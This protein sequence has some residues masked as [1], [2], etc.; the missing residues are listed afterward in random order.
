MT[1]QER[2]M[3]ALDQVRP[4]RIPRYEIL[5][6]SF[7]DAWRKES[8]LPAEAE[9]EAHCRIDIPSLLAVQAGPFLSQALAEHAEGSFL[10][11]R[12]SWGSAIRRLPDSGFT[13]TLSTAFWF[14]DDS[15]KA[16]ATGFAA[17]CDTL[18][19][20]SGAREAKPV[21]TAVALPPRRAAGLTPCWPA[22]PRLRFGPAP[23]GPALALQASAPSRGGGRA[24][25][26]FGRPGALPVPAPALQRSVFVVRASA[27]SSA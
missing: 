3:A 14:Y 17:L 7:T 16:W 18:A 9:A 10:L 6:R 11:S 20:S 26:R 12:D 4:D 2:A 22:G 15:K 24:Q 21:P 1:A 27:L 23:A 8:N 5:C 25:G 19:L 13:E